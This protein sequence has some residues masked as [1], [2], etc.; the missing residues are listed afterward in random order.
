MLSRAERGG[1]VGGELARGVHRSVA[2]GE[3]SCSTARRVARAFSGSAASPAS[4][5]AMSL[6]AALTSMRASTAA[7][8]S[9]AGSPTGR[10]R[11]SL[12]A[13]ACSRSMKPPDRAASAPAA[14]IIAGI[15]AESSRAKAALRPGR[16][17]RRTAPARRG[18]GCRRRGF[19]PRQVR[20][21]RARRADRIAQ[22]DGSESARR[23]TASAPE[24]CATDPVCLRRLRDLLEGFEPL[25]KAFDRL[26]HRRLLDAIS[27]VDFDAAI[28]RRQRSP[29]RSANCA[30]SAVGPA[31]A[32]VGGFGAA[33]SA[34]RSA[35]LGSA[36]RLS[37]E[38]AAICAQF[39][40][41]GFE[42]TRRDLVP[43]AFSLGGRQTKARGQPTSTAPMTAR[44]G[45]TRP[46]SQKRAAVAEAALRL[47]G[48]GQAPDRARSGFCGFG[49]LELAVRPLA[50][51]SRSG[52]WSA[53]A[54][55]G[56]F[57]RRGALVL[58]HIAAPDDDSAA[59]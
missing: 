5:P 26:R 20:R 36:G 30:R 43:T 28:E 7:G 34:W 19:S 42:R 40:T 17:L 16:R 25:G 32:R 47:C 8:S 29:Q 21:R 39:A 23:A 1:A 51:R 9:P 22:R 54:A 24:F 12:L 3:L 56:L 38:T 58:R 31:P 44:D 13:L 50:L 2:R 37:A 27:C 10:M 14:L 53:R 11:T 55:A 45:G 49:R 57:A 46:A 35:G 15:S 52:R 41:C 48:C 6:R 4:A 18:F 59:P 33:S